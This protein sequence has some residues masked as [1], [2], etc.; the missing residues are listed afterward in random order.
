MRGVSSWT[1]RQPSARSATTS[2]RTSTRL[3]YLCALLRGAPH[4]CRRHQFLTRPTDVPSVL[5]KGARNVVGTLVAKKR[6]PRT[7]PQLQCTSPVRSWLLGLSWLLLLPPRMLRDTMAP[8]FDVERRRR[9]R[10][11]NLLVVQST[12][13]FRLYMQ[14]CNF[15]SAPYLDPPDAWDLNIS[16]RRWK[17]LMRQYDQAIKRFAAN[18]TGC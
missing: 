17:W 18:C 8:P 2:S 7:A 4:E 5:K 10:I 14:E 1:S 12:P 16:V 6:S 3:L 15:G 13:A 11:F 9:K